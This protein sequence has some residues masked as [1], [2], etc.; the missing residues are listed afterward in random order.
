MK[1]NAKMMCQNLN[2][3][4]CE[5]DKKHPA[6]KFCEDLNNPGTDATAAALMTRGNFL[7]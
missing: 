4:N 2:N 1:S 3:V 5:N 7:L 6:A